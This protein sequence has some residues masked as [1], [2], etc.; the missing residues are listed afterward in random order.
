LKVLYVAMEHDYGDP[1]RGQSFEETNFRSA[2]EGMGHDIVPFDFIARAKRDGKARMRADLIAAAQ[3]ALPD[4]AFFT[5]Y[6]DELDAPTI[7][8]VG[9][10]CRTVN[11]FTDDHWRFDIFTRHIAG[12]FTLAVT[13]DADSLPKYAAAG[14]DRV[15]LSQWA[16]NR[17]AYSKVSDTLEHGVTFV[18]QPHG[19]R[20][21]IIDALRAAGIEVECWGHGW[22][23]GKLDHD[24]MVRVFATSAVNLNLSNSGEPAPTLRVRIGKLLG[25]GLGPKPPQIKGRNFEVPG[26][27]GF[28][29]TERVPHLE[30]YYAYDEEI[31]VHDDTDSLI[32]RTRYWLDHPDDRAAVAAAG[33]R[34]TLAEHTYDDRFA[35]IFQSLR[36]VEV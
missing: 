22:P 35:A 36:R 14:L 18:G 33:Y 7:E 4:L 34:R 11:W 19:G 12:A 15:H 20:G 6:Q 16:C 32:E 17:Y 24:E 5:L 2:L 8:A 1:S 3:E 13:T 29:L 26:C 9:K 10:V 28:L 31:G 27:G 30:R 21:E 23:A 25:R